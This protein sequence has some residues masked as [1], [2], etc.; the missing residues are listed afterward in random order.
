LLRGAV[1][2]PGASVAPQSRKLFWKLTRELI[3]IF[4]VAVAASILIKTYVV[5]SFYIP[6]ASMEDTLHVNDRII[7]NELGPRFTGLH[8]GE[9]VVFKDPGG[10]LPSPPAKSHTVGSALATAL[11]SVG[12]SAEDSSEY[13]VKRVIAVAGD[14]VSCCNALGQLTVNG[15]PLRE[16]YAVI[17]PGAVNAATRSFD[18]V[19]PR[20]S[21]WVMGD[22][23][24]D[25]RDSSLN[26]GLPGKGFVPVGDVVGT[27][28]AIT[29]PIGR[30]SWID[31]HAATFD[32]V[33]D[34]ASH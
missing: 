17:P 12:F 23:R 16:P 6:S 2:T 18:A 4:A 11:S 1:A 13:L 33:V 19:V 14:R 22:N 20:G 8:R 3:V 15:S 9:V 10:W 32:G 28:M 34:G 26:Q 30:W 7:V 27:A 21:I 31:S 29:W 24:Y 5:R 25:S